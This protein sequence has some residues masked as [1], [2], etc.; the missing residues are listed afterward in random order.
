[1]GEGRGFFRRAAHG[2]PGPPPHSDGARLGSPTFAA[3]AMPLFWLLACQ[4]GAALVAARLQSRSCSCCGSA[5]SVEL[6]VE[7]GR[8]ARFCPLAG[9]CWVGPTL[10]P[11]ARTSQSHVRAGVSAAGAAATEEFWESRWRAAASNGDS[12]AMLHRVGAAGPGRLSAP[13]R[14]GV[15]AKRGPPPLTVGMH[16]R[17]AMWMET[18]IR[19]PKKLAAKQ[20]LALA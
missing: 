10:L 14:S 11:T 9:L 17:P 20:R 16:S 13:F 6:V 15:R 5:A 7:H 12:S 8:P 19:A 18:P 2:T 3:P 4:C 1:M